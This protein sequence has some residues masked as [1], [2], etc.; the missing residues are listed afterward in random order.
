MALEAG[1]IGAGSG[2]SKEIYDKLN[3]LLSPKVPAENLA[4]AQKGW[5]ELA[6]AIATGVIAHVTNNLEVTVS[7]L[8]VSGSASLP[9]GS[10]G[11]ASGTVSLTQVGSTTGVIR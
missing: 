11:Q 6:F 4:D 9:V 10:G 3:E 2:M 1:D 8:E 7:G 5:K